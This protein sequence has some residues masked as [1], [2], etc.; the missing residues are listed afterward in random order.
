MQNSKQSC[1]K[2]LE[3]VKVNQPNFKERKSIQGQKL[4]VFNKSAW[5][6]KC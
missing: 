2:D 1:N 3:N 6:E 5:E 4:G